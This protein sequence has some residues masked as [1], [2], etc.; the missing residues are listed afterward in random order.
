M[1]ARTEQRVYDIVKNRSVKFKLIAVVLVVSLIVVPG[2]FWWL[3]L[4]GITMAGDAFCGIT[5]H[6]HDLACYEKNLICAD[7]SHEHTDEC[8]ETLNVCGLEEHIHVESCYSDAEADVEAAKDWE[9]TMSE[10]TLCGNPQE[11]LVAIAKTQLGYTESTRNFILDEDG[12]RRGYTRYGE[13]YGAP[14]AKWSAMFLSFCMKYADIST[15]IAPYNSGTHTM[16][17]TWG[18]KGIYFEKSSYSPVAG[19]V[20]FADTDSDENCDTVGIISEVSTSSITVIYGGDVSVKEETFDLSDG[21]VLGYGSILAI[22]ENSLSER[23]RSRIENAEK[24]IAAL[25]TEDEII[26]VTEKYD[27]SSKEFVEWYYNLSLSA[28]TAYVYYEDLGPALQLFVEGAEKLDGVS[29]LWQAAAMSYTEISSISVYQANKYSNALTT[30]SY[31]GSINDVMSSYLDYKYWDAIVIDK[32]DAGFYV[33]GINR[34]VESKLDMSPSTDEGFILLVWHGDSDI[35]LVANVQVGHS[36]LVS[37]V[38]FYKSTTASTSAIGTVTF[39]T[40]PEDNE[41]IN[42]DKLTIVQSADTSELIEVNLFDYGTNVNT[43]YTSS[44]HVYP[45]FQQDGGTKSIGSSIAQYSMNFGNNI[46]ADIGDII[47]NITTNSPGPINVISSINSSLTDVMASSLVDGY[48]ALASGESLD[49]LFSQNTYATKLNTES[50]N[51]LF[52][53]NT[54]TG[55]YYF[56]SRNN[57]AQFNAEDDTFTL[58]KQ[59]I[60]SNFTMYPFGNFLPL[61]DIVTETTQTTTI[62]ADWFTNIASNALY[63]YNNG[64]GSE[65]S[66]LNTVLTKFVSL[67][68]SEYGTGKW[69][70]RDA[71]DK[72]FSLSGISFEQTDEYLSDVYSIDFDEATNFF[73][74]MDMHMEF[75]QPKGGM[76]GLDGQQEMVFRFTGDDDVWVYVDGKLFLDLSGIHRHVGG[77][78]DF[79]RGVVEYYDLDPE[80]GDVFDEAKRTVTFAEILGS[81]DGLNDAG[82]F[83]DYSTHKMDFYYMERGAGSGICRMNF[84]MPLIHANSISVSKEL[85]TELNIEELLGNPDFSFQVVKENGEDLFIGAGVPYII[86]DS[87]GNEI[88]TDT[89]DVNGVFKLKSGQTAVFDNIS[90]DGDSTYFVREILDESVFEQYGT[91]SVDGH[92]VTSSDIDEDVEIGGEKFIGVESPVKNV[93]EGSASFAFNNILDANKFGSLKIEKVLLE[94]ITTIFTFYVTLDGEPLPVGTGYTVIDRTGLARLGVVE[95]EGMVYIASG[96]TACIENIIAGA[97][98]TMQEIGADE[99]GYTVFYRGDDINIVDGVAEGMIKASTPVQ[100]KVVNTEKGS[101]VEIPYEKTL[102]NPDTGGH[103]YYFSLTEVT[104]ST[105]AVALENGITME[106][107]IYVKDTRSDSYMIPFALADMKSD[108]DVYYF[109]VE[110]IPSSTDF[111][112]VYD[113]TFYV[114][115][116]TVSKNEKNDVLTEITGIWK[117]GSEEVSDETAHFTNENVRSVTISK[118][119]E[120][121][122]IP[123]DETFR[124]TLLLIHDDAYLAGEYPVTINGISSVLTV[125]DGI[126]IIYLKDGETAV[127]SDLPYGTEWT[128]SETTVDGYFPSYKLNGGKSEIGSTVQGQLT[129]NITVDYINSTGYVLPETGDN[130]MLIFALGGVMVILAPLVYGLMLRRRKKRKTEG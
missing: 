128:I 27:Q 93:D 125:S 80:T 122:D 23:D 81:T 2:V 57:H 89:T 56:N 96:E 52:Q 4:T 109:R 10:V 92:A 13:W 124:F 48:P 40:P 68:N 113:E 67:M 1:Q 62:D 12:N 18:R 66:T 32:N 70:Y 72:Y 25:P 99:L 106:G 119:V 90:D 14:Y 19:D 50:I 24:E 127:I 55:E 47:S 78:I 86:Y 41:E 31:G 101:Y 77:K 115:E 103:R 17:E 42:K 88:G 53:Y 61:N 117:N 20:M 38:D 30:I 121:E 75:I 33:S 71:I 110:E 126:G 84:N 51:G 46:T 116:V 74:G 60:T 11:D 105:G 22:I 6:V 45:G 58:Y 29:W 100:I 26:A 5:E 35:S 49:Y 83:A 7:E 114:Y 37:P 64:L 85:T 8:Y 44:N 73:F 9:M 129:D 98:F 82:T 65:Y 76:T 97:D 118:S 91:I 108:T 107:T 3:K 34:N 15:D 79:V 63:K 104:N 94:D 87:N 21:A 39:T 43:L 36:V 102:V 54:Q 16:L 28:K 111:T 95:V 123:T 69:D 130:A 59:I 120:G 112:T